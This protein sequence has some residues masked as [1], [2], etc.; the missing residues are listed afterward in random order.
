MRSLFDNITD[1]H[2]KMLTK[3]GRDVAS[4]H[5]SYLR[6][7][8]NLKIGQWRK[9]AAYFEWHRYFEQFLTTKD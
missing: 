2:C 4:G 9:K 7:G 8:S 1:N 3:Y 5:A 6:I